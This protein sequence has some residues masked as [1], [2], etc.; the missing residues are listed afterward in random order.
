MIMSALSRDDY[1]APKERLLSIKQNLVAT[2]K[3]AKV[4]KETM[5][6]YLSD[7]REVEKLLAD[8]PDTPIDSI[9]V[10]L[11][12]MMSSSRRAFDRQQKQQVRLQS[13]ANNNL[14]TRSAELKLI[15]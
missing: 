10:R 9:Y 3:V 4:S 11:G 6:K 5:V 15:K 8:V 13:L 12:R 2:L 14:F 7:I 1:M